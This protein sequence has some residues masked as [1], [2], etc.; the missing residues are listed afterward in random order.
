MGPNYEA[1]TGMANGIKE[2]MLAYQTQKQ[3]QRTQDMQGLLQGIQKNPET[4]ELEYTPQKQAEMQNARKKAEY[5][6]GLIDPTSKQSEIARRNYEGL[7]GKALDPE[8]NAEQVKGMIPTSGMIYRS[9]ISTKEK[10]A[11]LNEARKKEASRFELDKQKADIERKLKEAQIESLGK[12]SE[13]DKNIPQNVYAAATFAKRMKDAQD[14]IENVIS[15]GYDPTSIDAKIKSSK[16][17]PEIL[18]DQNQKLMDQAKKNFLTAQLRRE[19]GAT[20]SDA[21]FATGNSMYFPQPGDT[22]AVLAQKKRNREISIAG[23]EAEGAKA[24]PKLEQKLDANTKGLLPKSST[25]Q[26]T[27]ILKYSQEHGLSYDQA[28]QIL[29]KRGYGKQ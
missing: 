23:L 19:S 21:E 27:N 18:T 11:A 25:E 2:G 20:I 3:I 15:A 17:F 6:A 10:E 16:Y 22:E 24:L 8:T 1:M 13:S 29:L 28:K 7:I 14:N 4:G 9:D 5:D 26:D 12:K